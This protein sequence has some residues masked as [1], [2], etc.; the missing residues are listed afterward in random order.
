[1]NLIEFPRIMK[2]YSPLDFFFPSHLKNIKTYSLL[3]GQRGV[4]HIWPVGRKEFVNRAAG[5][6]SAPE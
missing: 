4:G 5:P 3:G 6:G 1:M 2:E